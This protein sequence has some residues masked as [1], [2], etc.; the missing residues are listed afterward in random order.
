MLLEVEVRKIVSRVGKPARAGANAR[1]QP[2]PL[3]ITGINQI[4]LAFLKFKATVAEAETSPN[5]DGVL[6]SASED[7]LNLEFYALTLLIK[8]LD[9]A[10]QFF[11]CLDASQFVLVCLVQ[12]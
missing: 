8:R 9:H 2:M 12:G 11:V 4:G 1:E 10:L 6:L 7:F 3:V 5:V